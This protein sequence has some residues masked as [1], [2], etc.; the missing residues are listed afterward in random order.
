MTNK[1]QKKM[2]DRIP[3]SS[4]IKDEIEPYRTRNHK[5]HQQEWLPL[6]TCPYF[7]FDNFLQT[8]IL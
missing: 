4:F 6:C 3:L 1:K 2:P 5:I 8:F 7:Y